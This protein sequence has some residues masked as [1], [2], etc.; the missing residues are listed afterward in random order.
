MTA[1]EVK[2][3]INQVAFS[4]A[5]DFLE[6]YKQEST[7][8]LV[9][10]ALG[11]YS[12]FMVAKE[13]E[14]ITRSAR[15]DESAVRWVCDGS[16][17]F[18]LESHERQEPGTDVVLHLMDEELEYLEPARIR[19]LITQYCDFM[20]VDVQ[21]EGESVNKRDPAWRKT[22]RDMTDQD[23]I[24]LYRYLYPFQGDPLLWVH[25]NN[26]DY[27]YTLQGILYFP[28]ALGRADWEKGDIR[29][30]CNQVYVSDSI[31]EIVPRYL[32]PLRG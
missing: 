17:A 16:P 1:D 26:T 10:S 12:S 15:P 27:P 19:T 13:V 14:L 28:Q 31:K 20:P 2:R 9:I 21:L 11:F 29:L 25:L 22:P 5:E 8:S 4:S 23:Y 32:L 7:Q 18:K 3:Y 6:K 24:D 30:Y